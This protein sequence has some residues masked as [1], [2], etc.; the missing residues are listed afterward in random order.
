MEREYDIF[1]H[2]P[3]GFPVWRDHAA[4]LTNA[5]LR[6]QQIAK[7]TPNECFAVHLPTREVVARVNVRTDKPLIFQIAYN[8]TMAAARTNLMRMHGYEVISVVGN[9]AAKV[10]L[11]APQHCDFFIVGHCAP[12]PV[13]AEMVAWVKRYYPQIPV[14]AL[15]PEGGGP[16]A[17]AEYN[18]TLDVR[19]EWLSVLATGFVTRTKPSADGTEP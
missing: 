5:T 2:Y 14:L 18:V 3:D 6:L 7:R 17:G 15:N 13:R 9:E 10:V 19:D 4:G 8:K 11:S 16:L 12:A 1:E